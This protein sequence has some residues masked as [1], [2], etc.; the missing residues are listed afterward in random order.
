MHW[1]LFPNDLSP[2]WYNPAG[3]GLLADLYALEIAVL[4]CLLP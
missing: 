1:W 3:A 4:W 2:K